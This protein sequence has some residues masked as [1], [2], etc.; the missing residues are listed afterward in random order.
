MSESDCLTGVEKKDAEK[1]HFSSDSSSN[2]MDI[3]NQITIQV[4]T[5]EQ[6]ENQFVGE[7]RQ[8]K[9]VGD[10]WMNNK[11]EKNEVKDGDMQNGGKEDSDNQ[12]K[13]LNDEEIWAEEG[14]VLGLGDKGGDDGYIDDSTGTENT[15]LEDES[16]LNMKQEEHGKNDATGDEVED[17]K[18]LTRVSS[19][20]SQDRVTS[21]NIN[22]TPDDIKQDSIPAESYEN[23]KP[24]EK[25]GTNMEVDGK[26]ET[27]VQ[28]SSAENTRLVEGVYRDA[29]AKDNHIVQE[30]SVSEGNAQCK[31]TNDGTAFD[32]DKNI[33]TNILVSEKEENT[34]LSE[35]TVEDNNVR[36]CKGTPD[37]VNSDQDND[38]PE[39]TNNYPES[40]GNTNTQNTA[41]NIKLTGENSHVQSDDVDMKWESDTNTSEWETGMFVTEVRDNTSQE[42]QVP[43]CQPEKEDDSS[44]FPEENT[45]NILGNCSKDSGSENIREMDNSLGVNS[46]NDKIVS[47][48]VVDDEEVSDEVETK[49]YQQIQENDDQQILPNHNN[50]AQEE[51]LRE[52]VES[53]NQRE[54][55]QS[56]EEGMHEEESK[57]QRGVSSVIQGDEQEREINV[58]DNAHDE[59][60]TKVHKRIISQKRKNESTNETSN[61]KSMKN[62][63][64]IK[65]KLEE[66]MEKSKA[67]EDKAIAELQK[68]KQEKAEVLESITREMEVLK[69]LLAQGKVH[70]LKKS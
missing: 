42:D 9:D 55:V 14:R 53:T 7:N 35:G 13:G 63:E 51:Q 69:S 58:K 70:V 19:D 65:Q 22:E 10:H 8:D 40:K 59:K 66:I 23:T 37:A 32:A 6:E 41:H 47:E 27:E 52:S 34:R 38:S 5:Q 25:M 57:S 31:N 67:E 43:E 61:K 50:A 12:K 54:G 29:A 16:C 30:V 68:M 2:S 48:R 33:D 46:E 1:Y 36:I 49:G 44:T 18:K 21:E 11:K 64:R 20:G 28:I 15:E 39:P 24:S 62:I 26:E 45:D 60:I 3:S 56:E 4:F 17:G